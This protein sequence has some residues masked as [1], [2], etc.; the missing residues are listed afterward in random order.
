[1]P[2]HFHRRGALA[3]VLGGAAGVL[4]APAL[5][6][7]DTQRPRAPSSGGAPPPSQT[8]PQAEAQFGSVPL[9]ETDFVL[10]DGEAP[11]TVIKYASMTCPHCAAFHA[12]TA[13]DL[14]RAHIPQ[15]RVR[16][17]HRHF[18][19]DQAA[20]AAAILLHCGTGTQ[21]RF[22][23]L[24]DILYAEQGDWTGSGDP[25]DAL[26][27]IAAR[28]GLN[29]DEFGACLS[30]QSLS[31]RIQTERDEGAE[32]YGV[33]ATPTLLIN[34][35]RYSGNLTTRQLDTIIDRIG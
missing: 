17:V 28:T 18:P 1:M 32:T 12:A 16:Y 5:A 24:L 33:R 35:A 15:G 10:G 30:D 22:F 13:A 20:M 9:R 6:W 21:D 31:R 26:R 34:G 19:L 11:I 14:K 3:A 25:V 29:A 8:G 7:H 4:A 23:A 27:G 2:D